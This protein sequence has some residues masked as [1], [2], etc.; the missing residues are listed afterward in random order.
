M[1]CHMYCTIIIFAAPALSLF[2]G[3]PDEKEAAECGLLGKRAARDSDDRTRSVPLKKIKR[4]F[5]S[6]CLYM[7][8]G[9]TS[10]KTDDY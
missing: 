6:L 8:S 9:A 10:P 1:P 3:L 7:Y 5:F 2:G 4:K